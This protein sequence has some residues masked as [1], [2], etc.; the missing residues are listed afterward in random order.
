MQ[1]NW[2]KALY[3]IKVLFKILVMVFLTALLA[4]IPIGMFPLKDG[5]AYRLSKNY[6]LWNW[7]GTLTEYNLKYKV[8]AAIKDVKGRVIK[9]A[10]DDSCLIVQ[11][12]AS[13]WYYLEPGKPVNVYGSLRDL[14]DKID[15]E[16]DSLSF[17]DSRPWLRLKYIYIIPISYFSFG[18]LSSFLFFGSDLCWWIRDRGK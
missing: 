15:C 13:L 18:L 6:E 1:I 14:N 12:D 8:Y 17:V 11:T 4:D 9:Y 7:P 16:V 2:N 10:I 3:M 5:G